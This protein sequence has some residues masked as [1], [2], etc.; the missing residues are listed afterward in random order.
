MDKDRIPAADIVSNFN[1]FVA[2]VRNRLETLIKQILV[3]SGGILTITVGA[4]LTSNK[5]QLPEATIH[6]FKYAWTSLTTSI[7]LCLLL[8]VLQVAA[9]INVAFKNK[10]KIEE[11][12]PGIEV[13]FAWRPL[14]ILNIFV[15][16]TAFSTCIS[17]I[18]FMSQAAISLLA[19]PT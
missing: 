10:D 2:E 18:I 6:L 3:V 12:R 11:Q 17:G 14:R 9:L 8:M 15:G 7:I 13:I 19:K 4:F 5:P 1:T 16:L